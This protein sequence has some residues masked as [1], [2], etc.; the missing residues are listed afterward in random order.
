MSESVTETVRVRVKISCQWSL[1]VL[2]VIMTLVHVTQ[3]A[4]CLLHFLLA[5]DTRNIK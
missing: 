1:C 2:L 4:S 5:T 3:H